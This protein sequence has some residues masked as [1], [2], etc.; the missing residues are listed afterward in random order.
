MI[1]PDPCPFCERRQVLTGK[2]IGGE[3]IGFQPDGT[4]KGFVLTLRDPFAFA[5][6]PAACY[7]AACGMVWSQAD[8]KDAAK[9]IKKFVPAQIKDRLAS[10]DVNP[11]APKPAPVQRRPPA[12]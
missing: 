2:V 7:C 3:G 6:G 5:I 12:P 8:A 9:F 1:S 11:P 4:K 10:L